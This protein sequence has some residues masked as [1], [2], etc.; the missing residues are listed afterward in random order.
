MT[1]P[2]PPRATQIPAR[3]RRAALLLPLGAAA[4]VIA[5]IW[6]TTSAL[7]PLP[8]RTVTMATGA[9]GGAYQEVG[10]RYREVLGRHGITLKLLPTAGAL[11]NL[12]LLRD[13]RSGV[14]I[15]LLQGGIT[16]QKES[17]DLAA[18]G[19]VF[20]EPLWF[21]HR[22]VLEGRD[23]EAL[24]GRKISIG[25]EGSGTR[26]LV[27]QLL[28]RQRIGQG[29]AQLLALSH[30]EAAEALIRGEIDAAFMLAAWDSP[31][32][33]QLVTEDGIALVSF[34][35][36]DTYVALYPFLSKLTLPAGVGDMAKNRPPA[37]VTLFA[38]KASLVVRKDLHPAIQSLLLDAAEQVHSGP[39]IFHQTRQFPTAEAVDLPLSD[40]ARQYY[41]S[42]RPF[43]QRNLPFWLAV[44]IGRLLVFLIP[45]VGVM[46]PLFRLTPALY[47][48]NV[49]RR[50]VRMYRDLKDLEEDAPSP[51]ALNEGLE[52]LEERA[53][54][55][56]VPLFYS[57]S[58][59]TLRLHIAMV[60]ERL[61]GLGRP[62]TDS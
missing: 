16:S 19:T 13:P 5:A 40:E 45:L 3:H 7:S 59:Y 47:A 57:D 53:R 36:A 58:L 24:R 21:F 22:G 15:G 37:A 60:R 20:Y 51:G 50:I 44:A 26:A 6:Y 27:L 55:L 29:F 1:P 42:G 9:D 8:P 56:Q 4:L 32:V 11:E 30:Q 31:A 25:P 33:R 54:H 18:L 61:G 2:P 28:A 38:P 52:R 17:P 49:R 41:R 34:P 35:R 43:L 12:A 39:G 48:W 23:L 62:P 10:K 14:G 46:Y